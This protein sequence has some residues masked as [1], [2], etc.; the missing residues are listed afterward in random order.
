MKTI[1]IASAKGG[2]CKTSVTS[3]LAVRACQ[4][5]PKVAMMDLDFGQGSLK[6]WWGCRGEPD[7]PGLALNIKNI[8]SDVR[9]LASGYEWLF[10][11][12]PPADM[13]LIENAIAVADSVVV[14]VR[15]GFFD[16]VA[17]QSVVDMAKEHRKPFAFLLSAVDTRF[18]ALTTQTI[19]ALRDLGPL[20]AAR[21]SYRQTQIQAVTLGKTGPELDKE[22]RPEI[23]A[24]WNELKQLTEKGCV[25]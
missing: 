3:V 14:P 6:Q 13:D 16:V 4:D 19:T 15:P 10:I 21:T 18:K 8:A 1:T 7:S 11:D 24:L 12:T 20:F 22:L 17:V 25:Q 2:S 9:T 23:D 5:T